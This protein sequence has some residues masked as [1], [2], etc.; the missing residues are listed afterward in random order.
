MGPLSH[1][2]D[3]IEV[4][5]TTLLEHDPD[6]RQ[7]TRQQVAGEGITNQGRVHSENIAARSYDNLLFRSAPEIYFYAALRTAGVAFAPLSV[8]IGRDAVGTRPR[9]IEPDFVI[10][11]DGL[12]TIV[13]I[14]GD[15][16]HTETPQQAHLRLKFLIDEGA[17]LERINASQCDS[18]EKAREAV[19]R[20]LMD[21]EKRRR[22]RR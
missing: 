5:L 13:E 7:K 14:D 11:K 12:V 1:G 2:Q 18:R 9:R 22:Q 17:H 15:L 3:S 21:I 20:I 6:W 10:Y 8:I 4:E 16:W 19:E